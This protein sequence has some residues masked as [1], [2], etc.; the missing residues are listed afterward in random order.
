MQH[1]NVKTTT[2]C[3]SSRPELPNSVIFGV[4][5]GTV[6]KPNVNYLKKTQPVTE[7]LLKLASPVT[8]AEVFRTA[9]SCATNKCQHFDGN[10]CRLAQRVV[11]KL[12]IT[13]EKLPPCAIRKDCR[14]FQ[15]E[16]KAACLRCPQ[17]I[18]DNYH[19]SELVREVSMPTTIGE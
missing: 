7:K 5:S 17:I 19:A 10:N 6:E 13:A 1:D 2:L 12:P 11:E 3:P 16:G 4:I 9:S 15:Q 18:T 8:P 14:W